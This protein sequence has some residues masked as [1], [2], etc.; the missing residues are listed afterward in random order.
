MGGS[1]NRR[2]P[3][4]R[5][6]PSLPAPQAL[7][8]PEACAWVTGDSGRLGDRL[9]EALFVP[10]V[11]DPTEGDILRLPAPEQ[12]RIRVWRAELEGDRAGLY[13]WDVR[14]ASLLSDQHPRTLNAIAMLLVGVD[15]LRAE[16]R[17]VAAQLGVL[18]HARVVEHTTTA[19]VLFRPV[20][21]PTLE[22]PP[23]GRRWK[24][25]TCSACGER[26]PRDP[27]LE[28]GCPQCPARPGATCVRPSEH[29]AFGA[30]V[31]RYR[32]LAAIALGRLRPCPAAPEHS[33]PIGTRL[34]YSGCPDDRAIAREEVRSWVLRYLREGTDVMGTIGA[35]ERFDFTS[36]S[37]LLSIAKCVWWALGMN[38]IAWHHPRWTGFVVPEVRAF[39]AEL[40][41][42]GA[43]LIEQDA[44]DKHMP[45]G[46]AGY[47]P[48][49]NLAVELTPAWTLPRPTRRRRRR[50]WDQTHATEGT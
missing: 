23:R 28:V 16:R 11:E 27:A 3:A 18:V 35:K 12:D 20:A 15:A 22:A 24:P 49:P 10:S 45:Y 17:G 34:D 37:S 21:Y 7:Q 43:V 33:R 38:P 47:R 6:E 36:A 2:K 32:E 44:F 8:P 46:R 9:G 40:G 25:A 50:V 48:G 4:A 19:P 39:L 30:A 42:R 1:V 13:P 41:E 31:H 29:R 14:L 5:A 26:W